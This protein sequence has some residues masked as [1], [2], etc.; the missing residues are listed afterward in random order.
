MFCCLESCQIEAPFHLN[1]GRW[2]YFTQETAGHILDFT[3]S[4]GVKQ[5]EAGAFKP[6]FNLMQRTLVIEGPLYRPKCEG[7]EMGGQNVIS[8]Q[9]EGLFQDNGASENF[10]QNGRRSNNLCIPV[11][12]L[13]K[14]RAVRI[15]DDIRSCSNRCAGL[16]RIDG[17]KWP[18]M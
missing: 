9:T 18:L 10:L 11:E 13:A 14:A 15:G 2:P 3:R 17:Q 16:C 1:L 8:I 5:E 6:V 7:L 4:K 12:A